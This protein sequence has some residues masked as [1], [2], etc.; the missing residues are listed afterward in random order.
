[1]SQKKEE[2]EE[3]KEKQETIWDAKAKLK[4]KQDIAKYELS[5]LILKAFF[6]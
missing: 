1:M 3:E 4:Y 2:K 5:T 6:L